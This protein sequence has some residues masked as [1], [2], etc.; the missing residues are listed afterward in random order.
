MR[1]AT[2]I[3]NYKVIQQTIQHRR[4]L[5]VAENGFPEEKAHLI[6]ARLRERLGERVRISTERV[7]HIPRSRSGNHRYV[8]SCMPIPER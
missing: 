2:G 3:K 1:D 4:V 5:L 6:E 8:E 7:E